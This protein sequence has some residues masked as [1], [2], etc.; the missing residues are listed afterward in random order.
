M[1]LAEMSGDNV[2][3]NKGK[4]PKPGAPSQ[5]SAGAMA[6]DRNAPC[7]SAKESSFPFIDAI[8]NAKATN[9]LAVLQRMLKST[10]AAARSV[11]R[12]TESQRRFTTLFTEFCGNAVRCMADIEDAV[13]E[14]NNPGCR[15]ADA[16]EEAVTGIAEPVF[17][18]QLAAYMASHTAA[19]G[20]AYLEHVGRSALQ[21]Q[22]QQQ[23]KRERVGEGGRS[24]KNS[25]SRV[26]KRSRVQDD[27]VVGTAYATGTIG[28]GE[29]GLLNSND[30]V[31]AALAAIESGGGGSDDG[32]SV[33]GANLEG[34]ARGG[35]G[36]PHAS[37]TFISKGSLP[38]AGGAVKEKTTARDGGE[39]IYDLSNP[40]LRLSTI[41]ELAPRMEPWTIPLRHSS[42]LVERVTAERERKG[43]TT[44]TASGGNSSNSE[45]PRPLCEVC[46]APTPVELL[47][48]WEQRE[49]MIDSEPLSF[50]IATGT[51]TAAS[52]NSGNAV[53][54]QSG[55]QR[56][57]SGGV[58]PTVGAL[59][60]SVSSGMATSPIVP[61]ADPTPGVTGAKAYFPSIREGRRPSSLS[62][63]LMM[64]LTHYGVSR[65]EYVY[66]AP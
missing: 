50:L 28:E 36:Q 15:A 31:R 63:S 21:K 48:R 26:A 41:A 14:Y 40:Q 16:P 46:L 22:I 60:F 18:R 27:S 62:S 37:A 42:I 24:A 1:K 8:S 51:S 32:F 10:V 61:V 52:Q 58:S 38:P 53:G 59:P 5:E 57:L 12:G 17:L 35:L 2:S 33:S 30:T 43:A 49:T 9:R 23:H 11:V 64:D 25:S 65:I 39:I 29:L 56:G 20:T 19:L 7:T 3:G 34:T 45:G 44:A 4:S 54:P 66:G 55:S 47:R 6:A 13:Y